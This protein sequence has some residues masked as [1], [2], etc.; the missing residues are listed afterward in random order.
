MWLPFQTTYIP[1]L[2]V[3]AI[4]MPNITH[5]NYTTTAELVFKLQTE[6]NIVSLLLWHPVF[7]WECPTSQPE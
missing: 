2:V 6:R 7:N 1:P 5:A 3:L 4:F